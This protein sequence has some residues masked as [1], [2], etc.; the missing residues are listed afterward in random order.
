MS[1]KPAKPFLTCLQGWEEEHWQEEPAGSAEAQLALC[2]E[3]EDRLTGP[4]HHPPAS[5]TLSGLISIGGG[6][7]KIIFNLTDLSVFQHLH[8]IIKP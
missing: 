5:K 2:Q 1:W 3:V 7:K 8:K 6:K 4:D